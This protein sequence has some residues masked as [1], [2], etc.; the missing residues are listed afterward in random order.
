MAATPLPALA[1]AV[2]IPLAA[3][4]VTQTP[5]TTTVRTGSASVS[6][7][8]PQGASAGSPGISPQIPAEAYG[9]G[10]PEA[11]GERSLRLYGP[12]VSRKRQTRV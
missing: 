9:N 8:P 10:G 12:G 1:L 11:G 5:R 4:D 7:V 6:A 3:C 2:L